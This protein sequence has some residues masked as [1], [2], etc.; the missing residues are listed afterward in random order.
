VDDCLEIVCGAE[1]WSPANAIE[2]IQGKTNKS[3]DD[4][5]RSWKEGGTSL[6][7]SIRDKPAYSE[8]I[9][10]YKTRSAFVTIVPCGV[11]L[12]DHLQSL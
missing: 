6:Q 5:R 8:I 11:K 12:S 3:S 10:K 4:R 7:R 1:G 9:Y 2:Y